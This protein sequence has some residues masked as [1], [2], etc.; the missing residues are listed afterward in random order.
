MRWWQR[1]CGYDGGRHHFVGHWCLWIPVRVHICCLHDACVELRSLGLFIVKDSSRYPRLKPTSLQRSFARR[2]I[3]WDDL[4]RGHV[5]V[6]A[7]PLTLTISRGKIK[8]SWTRRLVTTKAPWIAIVAHAAVHTLARLIGRDTLPLT[9]V[10]A[11][12]THGHVAAIVMPP[13]DHTNVSQTLD[14]FRP[15]SQSASC[16]QEDIRAFSEMPLS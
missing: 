14:I 8:R 12:D 15:L 1:T 5:G 9:R 13:F 4:K 10:W 16:Q 6:G 3:F 7:A 2:W 11:P